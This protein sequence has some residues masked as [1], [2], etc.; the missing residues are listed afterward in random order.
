MEEEAYQEALTPRKIQWCEP[1]LG[2]KLAILG[3][4]MHCELEGSPRV[5]TFMVVPTRKTHVKG[6]LG[7]AGAGQ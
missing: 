7:G 2:S 4:L 1:G 3:A 6:V 5:S